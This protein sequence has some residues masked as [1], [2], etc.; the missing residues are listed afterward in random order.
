MKIR[1]KT[2]EEMESIYGTDIDGDICVEGEEAF[3]QEMEE[4]CGK[5]VEIEKDEFGRVL[6]FDE[7]CYSWNI[8]SYMVD[9]RDLDKFLN[10]L[11]D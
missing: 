9:D 1:I 6:A 2:W 4:F 3:T 8:K 10:L 7:D 5:E 11:N